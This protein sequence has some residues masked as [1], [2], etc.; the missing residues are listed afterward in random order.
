MALC[1][2]AKQTM[3]AQVEVVH[4]L[5]ISKVSKWEQ[6]AEPNAS[7]SVSTVH[8]SCTDSG[9]IASFCFKFRNEIAKLVQNS[10]SQ[11]K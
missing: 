11:L 8:V 5:S 1:V 7:Y 3:L 4:N 2:Y 6:P 9:G 10:R